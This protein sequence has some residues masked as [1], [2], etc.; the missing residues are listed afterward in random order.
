VVKAF[1]EAWESANIAALVDLLDPDASA[2]VD[3]GGLV[4]AELRPV[5]GAEHVAR[6]F[7]GILDRQAGLEIVERPVNGQPG[8]VAQVGGVPLAVIAVD[9]VDDTVKHLWAVR[10]PEK[11][12]RWTDG[13]DEQAR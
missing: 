6:L 10:N 12:R 7:V 8:L 2:V 3:G 13:G 11:L 1:K 5:V 4:S 9:V